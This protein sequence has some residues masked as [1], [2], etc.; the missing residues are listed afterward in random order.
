MNN[1][2]KPILTEISKYELDLG[3]KLHFFIS[4]LEGF[5]LKN[6]HVGNVTAQVLKYGRLGRFGG[7]KAALDSIPLEYALQVKKIHHVSN[8]I[9]SNNTSVS[10]QEKTER[11]V[12]LRFLEGKFP[13]ASF[14]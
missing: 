8:S 13:N 10:L 12:F 1:Q 3:E 9:F 7:L 11:M 2:F 6:F 4:V 14:Q 5:K